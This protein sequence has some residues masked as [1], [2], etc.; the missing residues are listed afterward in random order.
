MTIIPATRSLTA[1]AI[2]RAIEA[3]KSND[4]DVTL[5]CSSLGHEC[6][7]LVWYRFRWAHVRPK[8]EARVQ[9]IF[10]NGH[11]REARIIAYLRE[12]GIA[13][14]THGPDGKQ[15]EIAISG[16]LLIGHLDGQAMSVPE[17]PKTLHVLEIKT[18]KDSRWTTW[19][20]KG[21]RV[22]DPVYFVQIQL[23]M[24][25]IGAT[26]CLF[27]AENQDTKELEIE[28]IEYDPAFALAQVAR[29]ERIAGMDRP[30]ARLNENPDWWQCRVC[31]ARTI[32]HGG[33]LPRRNCRTCLAAEVT[34]EKAAWQ[35]L[36]H[37]GGDLSIEDQ[38]EGC[39]T[40]LYAI[41]LVPFE[42]VDAD[43]GAMTVTYR[44]PDGSIWIDGAKECAE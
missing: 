3:R 1:A 5:R 6:D 4:D 37:G 13:V 21:V 18:M 32:C 28:R 24:H 30:P 12:A 34:P 42:Q 8:I 35:C 27:V 15:I 43:H 19:R 23:Y 44:K 2:D 36:R 31:E 25:A 10:E 9:R 17:A 16:R 7:R 38:R 14:T 29:A 33:E 11:D 20:R 39:V 40:H 26:R 41:G 22:S